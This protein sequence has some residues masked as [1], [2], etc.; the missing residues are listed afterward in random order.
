MTFSPD[1]KLLVYSEEGD[2]HVWE[3]A[4]GKEV[5]TFQGH[6]GGVRALTFSANGRR[7]A[8]SSTDSTVVIWDVAGVQGAG[9][10]GDK[11]LAAWWAGLA[12]DDAAQAY[13]AVWQLATRP[14]A[15][16]P[17][18]REHL[19]PVPEAQQKEIARH[20]KDLESEEFKVWQRALEQIEALGPD[21]I[22]A[23]R[24]ALERHLLPEVRNR[25]TSLLDSLM[26]K[27]LAGEPL[28]ANR[29]LA[30]LEYAGTP[31]ARRLLQSLAE[32]AS[33]AWLTQETKAS[34]DRLNRQ[35]A[36]VP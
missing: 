3:V 27:P 23:L 4:T 16:V 29:A 31:E 7:L 24:Q 20:V 33:G 19:K 2:V 8:S 15:S 14:E 34:L 28:R 12:D 5:R 13:A 10:P 25:V 35:T 9:K 32:G 30:A 21:A 1:N 26:A 17:F 22:P 18:L 36:A 11:D 6:H